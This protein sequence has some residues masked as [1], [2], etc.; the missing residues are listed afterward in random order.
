MS[1]KKDGDTFLHACS[2]YFFSLNNRAVCF[3]VGEAE[4]RPFLHTWVHAVLKCTGEAVKFST[5]ITGSQYPG[6]MVWTH[7]DTEQL[8]ILGSRPCKAN[9][10]GLKEEASLKILGLGRPFVLDSCTHGNY[11]CFVRWEDSV[12]VAHGNKPRRD[13]PELSVVFHCHPHLLS[14]AFTHLLPLLRSVGRV[15]DHYC[16]GKGTHKNSRG[17]LALAGSVKG[18]RPGQSSRHATSPHTALLMSSSS[19]HEGSTAR[20]RASTSFVTREA[21]SKILARLCLASTITTL[22]VKIT[23]QTLAKGYTSPWFFIPSTDTTA[24]SGGSG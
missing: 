18:T 2:K 13:S 24:V 14:L 12:G 9:T 19:K 8:A 17:Y 1:N 15:Q 21:E 22:S 20:L 7:C 11:I 5:F 10:H 16:K 23:K 3:R 4:Q 6:E